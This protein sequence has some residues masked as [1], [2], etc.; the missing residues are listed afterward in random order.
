M[1]I[2]EFFYHLKIFVNWFWADIFQNDTLKR[3]K[4]FHVKSE[5]QKKISICLWKY[6]ARDSWKLWNQEPRF[7]KSLNSTISMKFN[8][9]NTMKKARSSKNGRRHLS[10]SI[11]FGAETDPA[12]TTQSVIS[13][14]HPLFNLTHNAH[15]KSNNFLWFQ[16]F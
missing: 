13:N 10:I 14:A 1:E 2:Q 12:L 7:L 11:F 8:K 9:G 16:R 5:C 6:T 4:W 15:S 3:L